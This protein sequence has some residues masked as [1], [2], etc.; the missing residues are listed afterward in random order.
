MKFLLDT[1]ALIYLASKKSEPLIKRVLS[2]QEGDIGISSIVAH[3]LYFGAYNS[4]KIEHNLES[5]RL[6]LRNFVILEFDE[7]DARV[8]GEIRSQLKSQG[9]PIGAYDVLIAGQAKARSLI[10]I[11]HNTKEFQRVDGLSFEDWTN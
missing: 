1:N 11:T 9:T 10:L 8:S 6:L 5:L 4:Q 2:C 7:E 3:E